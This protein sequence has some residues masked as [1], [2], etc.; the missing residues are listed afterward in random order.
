MDGGGRQG[1]GRDERRKALVD[2]GKKVKDIVEMTIQIYFI[3]PTYYIIYLGLIILL[4]IFSY[5]NLTKGNNY[6]T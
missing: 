6:N 5:F 3:F 1:L 2:M 4:I